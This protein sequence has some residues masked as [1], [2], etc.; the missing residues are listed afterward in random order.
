MSVL[1][2]IERRLPRVDRRLRYRYDATMTGSRFVSALRGYSMTQLRS[3]ALSGVIV[4]V[5]AVP[6]SIAVAIAS[7]VGP[8]QGLA[9]AVIAGVMVALFGGG[10]VQISGPTGTFVVIAYAVGVRYGYAGLALATL[11]A[12][13]MLVA[14]G[15]ARLGRVIQFV[16]YP[17]VIGFTSGIAT[18]ILISQV[19]DLL[20]MGLTDAP[21]DAPARIVAYLRA[22]GNIRWQDALVAAGT[23]GIVVGWKRVSRRVPGALVAIVAATAVTAML[24][25][26]VITIESRFGALP[27]GL[28]WYGLPPISLHAV[29]ELFVPA[30]T[31]ALLCGI[32]SLLTAVVSDGM[33]GERSNPNQELIG[34]GLAN[35]AAALFGGIPASGAIART[36]TNA[37]NGGRTP[38]AALVNALLVLLVMSV[39]APL[40]AYIP[41]AAL[42]GVLCVVA[43]SMAEWRSFAALARGPKSDLAVLLTTFALTV[44]VDLSVAIQVGM[45]L[46]AFLFMRRMSIV[47]QVTLVRGREQHD[48]R[49]QHD[50]ELYQSGDEHAYVR[51]AGESPPLPDVERSDLKIPPDVEVYDIN[52]PF[53]FG[54]AEKFRNAMLL[55]TRRPRV[56]IVRMR[57]VGAIDATG[58]R[59]LE[60]LVSDS[61]HH[62]TRFIL[63]GLQPQPERALRKAGLLDR[64]G[65]EN[66]ARSLAEALERAQTGAPVARRPAR[67][68]GRARLKR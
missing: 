7:G 19:G 27:R 46:A 45:V 58:L 38:I 65:P 24:N 8:Q 51:G 23:I 32:E 42:S 59:L 31:I 47:A 9:T 29:R 66:V 36:A 37:R 50:P 49:E 22:Y 68:E 11:M 67:H 63:S 53:F 39:L 60:D 15:A 2:R 34:E 4:G 41:I 64:L 28:Q 57:A 62:K 43:F 17:V 33:I 6:L 56:R 1:P 14:M 40:A 16:P 3:D 21:P 26:P 10:S 30:F 61:E 13:L 5:I 18:V 52:G 25:A 48:E 12:G 55:I 35:A 20:G 44:I 54:A